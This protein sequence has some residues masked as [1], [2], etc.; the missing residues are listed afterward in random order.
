MSPTFTEN[1]NYKEH[2][3]G[4]IISIQS[5]KVGNTVEIPNMGLF[6]KRKMGMI[7]IRHSFSKRLFPILDESE[8][9]FQHNKGLFARFR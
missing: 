4:K 9:L 5:N 1:R 8:S 3:K 2:F 7:E 6:E